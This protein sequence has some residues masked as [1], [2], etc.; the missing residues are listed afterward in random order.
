MFR[1]GLKSDTCKIHISIPIGCEVFR[2]D[3]KNTALVVILLGS[4]FKKFDGKASFLLAS[5][6]SQWCSENLLLSLSKWQI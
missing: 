4:A 6:L 5:C 2:A 1:F 3:L